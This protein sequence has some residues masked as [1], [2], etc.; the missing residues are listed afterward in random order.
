MKRGFDSYYG[1]FVGDDEEH[2]QRS[3]DTRRSNGFNRK[4]RRKKRQGREIRNNNYKKVK[5][6]QK[7]T[8]DKRQEWIKK[9]KKYKGKGNSKQKK[10]YN[11]KKNGKQ[12]SIKKQQNKEK[13]NTNPSRKSSKF[14]S[15]IYGSKAIEI[16]KSAKKTKPFFI[17]LALLTKSYPR[18]VLK[19]RGDM[20]TAVAENRRNK[21][22]EMDESVEEIVRALKASDQYSNTVIFFISDNGA[23]ASVDSENRNNPNYPLRGSKGTVYEGG[24][25]VPAFIHSPHLKTER[26]R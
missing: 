8:K 13:V 22:S 25:K 19:K 6:G 16:I 5:T 14:G 26:K 12:P 10:F 15:N 11:K 4:E 24:T 3:K 18:E 20:E 21:L 2:T 1:L 7:I 23:R 9:N 17:Y